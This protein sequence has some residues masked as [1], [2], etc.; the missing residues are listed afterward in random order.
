MFDFIVVSIQLVEQIVGQ[1]LQDSGLPVTVSVLRTLRILRLMRI[2]RVVRLLR[3]FS[4][5]RT[6]ISAIAGSMKPLCSV[7]SLFVLLIYR[8]TV[9][10]ICRTPPMA[11]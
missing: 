2:I 3:Y 9:L 5:L 1:G 8:P 11:W 6:I 10:V 7:I 4:E